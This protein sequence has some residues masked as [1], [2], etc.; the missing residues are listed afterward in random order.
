MFLFLRYSAN[1]NLNNKNK[2]Y[3]KQAGFLVWKPSVLSLIVTFE[4]AWSVRHANS[5][6]MILAG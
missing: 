2:N 6:D 4:A 1:P 3:K 5:V